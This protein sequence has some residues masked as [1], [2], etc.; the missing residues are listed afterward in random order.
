MTENKKMLLPSP[1]WNGGIILHFI[2]QSNRIWYY[3][4]YRHIRCN[5]LN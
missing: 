1:P 3:S 2:H 5:A 4:L